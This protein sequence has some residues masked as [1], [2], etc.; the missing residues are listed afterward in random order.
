VLVQL[1]ELVEWLCAL[2]TVGLRIVCL[3]LHACEEVFQG[4]VCLR[5]MLSEDVV[6]FSLRS[7]GG[8]RLFSGSCFCCEGILDELWNTPR[9]P[10]FYRTLQEPSELK[11]GLRT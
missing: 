4:L 8:R 9:V 10:W 2:E 5:S 6:Q 3:V 11:G 1:C 7:L